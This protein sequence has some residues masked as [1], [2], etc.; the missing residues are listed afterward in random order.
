VTDWLTPER[1]DR[2][3]SR[4]D[5]LPGLMALADTLAATLLPKRGTGTG[6]RPTPGSRPPVS[7][8]LIDATDSRRKA[9]ARELL[10]DPRRVHNEHL[11]PPEASRL[12]RWLDEGARHGVL[13]TLGL[14]VRMA[15]AEMCDDGA[16]HTDPAE[17]PTV[18][19]EA[20]WLAMHLD[21]IVAQQW[22]PELDRDVAR[23]WG[24][25]RRATGERP[26]FRPRCPECNGTLVSHATWWECRACGRDWRDDRMVVSCQK[27]MSAA[28][29][30]RLFEINHSTIRTWA[31]RGDLEQATDDAGRPMVDGR[32]PLYHV[33]DVLRLADEIG[34]R[35]VR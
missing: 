11:D 4:L 25:L 22:A 35:R 13:P 24:E 17:H 18:T 3:K 5:D 15:E 10:A 29:I 16:E 1:R 8:A 6:G 26:E 21:W 12:A 9:P 33:A 34:S 20:G 23:M 14:W 2:L 27:P 32:S 30:S 28:R 7:L 31:E 19:T